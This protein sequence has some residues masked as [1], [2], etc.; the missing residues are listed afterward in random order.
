MLQIAKAIVGE[1]DNFSDEQEKFGK[2]C[3]T[4]TGGGHVI[5]DFRE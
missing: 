3:L 1:G 4:H 5:I 2:K